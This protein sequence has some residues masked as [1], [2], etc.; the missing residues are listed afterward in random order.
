MPITFKR[1]SVNTLSDGHY[2]RPGEPL[3][4]QKIE[5][6]RLLL[7][8]YYDAV[9]PSLFDSFTF[10][11][12]NAGPGLVK[13]GNRAERDI[14]MIALDHRFHFDKY[15]FVEED[16]EAGNALS[17]RV[18]KSPRFRSVFLLR[19]SLAGLKDRIPLYVLGSSRGYRARTLCFWEIKDLKVD[20]DMLVSLKE[21]GC[22]CL[23]MIDA[24]A[25]KDRDL[26]NFAES[27]REML[28]SF[29]GDET[30]LHHTYSTDSLYRHAVKGFICK[31]RGLGFQVQGGF[32]MTGE[33]LWYS[34]L[35]MLTT[36][37]KKVARSIERSASVQ[38]DLFA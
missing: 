27:N 3:T 5:Q 36:S 10:M 1:A 18:R 21:R 29:S 38:Y 2:I 23:I 20:F 33:R 19:G 9:D 31:M 28:V 11:A 32:H 26:E 34:G 17:L 24:I 25:L 15:I 8:S 7:T 13:I 16:E 22:D 12:V 14:P 6:F 4:P 30:V 35:F 37:P